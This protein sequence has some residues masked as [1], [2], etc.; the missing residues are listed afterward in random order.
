MF[1]AQIEFDYTT[2]VFIAAVIF[3]YCLQLFMC[4]KAKKLFVKLIPVILFALA[5]IVMA[6]LSAVAS[7]WDAL[8]YLFFALLFFATLCVCGFAWATFGACR[9]VKNKSN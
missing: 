9:S 6:I 3:A 8:G 4:F 2:V 1:G 5:M 7:G